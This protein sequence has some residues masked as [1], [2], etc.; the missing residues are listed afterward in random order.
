M[1]PARPLDA[2]HRVDDTG[3]QET[4]QAACEVEP[5]GGLEKGYEHVMDH[6][7]CDRRVTQQGCCQG[8]QVC[9]VLVIDLVQ[10]VRPTVIEL[11]D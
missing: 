4:F 2:P 7:L 1:P 10:H 11:P 5:A 9:F 3:N 8:Q 6:V